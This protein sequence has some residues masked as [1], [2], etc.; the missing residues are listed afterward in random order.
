MSI[1]DVRHLQAGFTEEA[2]ALLR[3]PVT[4]LDA[5]TTICETYLQDV[6]R[7]AL[8]ERTGMDGYTTAPTNCR[9]SCAC[10][11]TATSSSTAWR[12]TSTPTAWSGE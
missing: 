4:R 5:I 6:D 2:A 11:P 7:R 8:F 10:A 12:S 9:T 1:L 3:D